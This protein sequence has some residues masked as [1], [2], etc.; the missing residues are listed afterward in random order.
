ME[1]HAAF[2]LGR[3]GNNGYDSGSDRSERRLVY[4]CV[5]RNAIRR[6]N[7]FVSLAYTRHFLSSP[8]VD[9]F[10]LCR[11]RRPAA[12]LSDW[13]SYRSPVCGRVRDRA[14]TELWFMAGCCLYLLDVFLVPVRRVR[15]M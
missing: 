11:Q 5:V 2:S 15:D 7:Q 8:D 13:D 6:R 3:C 1:N 4:P 10:A 12:T 14:R 9:P